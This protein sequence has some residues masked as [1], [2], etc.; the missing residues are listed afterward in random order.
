MMTNDYLVRTN[1]DADFESLPNGKGHTNRDLMALIQ[2]EC[3][4]NMRGDVQVEFYPLVTGVTASFCADMGLNRFGGHEYA[5]I[6]T[7]KA[8]RIQ[9]FESIIKALRSD[10]RL[11]D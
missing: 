5:H 7:Y 3:R 10:Y 9:S 11:Y 1:E 8:H 4:C 6:T 2:V